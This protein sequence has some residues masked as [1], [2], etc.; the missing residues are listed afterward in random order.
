MDTYGARRRARLIDGVLPRYEA[1]VNPARTRIAFVSGPD[2]WV[3][4]VG[5]NTV[6]QLTS[7]A[8]P[9]VQPT[10]LHDGRVLWRRN[11]GGSSWQLQ[12]IT[13]D[14]SSTGVM[15]YPLGMNPAGVPLLP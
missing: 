7:T 13:L 5:T 12:W 4:V 15:G 6:S 8:E 14:L 2:I 9:D 10:F 11:L 3:N 1:A